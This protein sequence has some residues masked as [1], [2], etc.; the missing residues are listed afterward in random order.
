MVEQQKDHLATKISNAAK[1]KRDDELRDAGLRHRE[2][3]ARTV[4]DKVVSELEGRRLVLTDDDAVAA[5]SDESDGTSVTK[6]QRRNLKHQL[7]MERLLEEDREQTARLQERR[8]DLEQNQFNAD[9]EMRKE[10]IALR[11]QELKLRHTKIQNANQQKLKELEMRQQAFQ[12]RQQE[13]QVEI[14]RKQDQSNKE[15]NFKLKKLALMLKART[16]AADAK[17]SNN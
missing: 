14:K 9:L 11:R 12:M 10:E 5:S 1:R 8:L 2:N 17:Q 15:F 16:M 13:F 4:Y 7:R 6:R 3:V